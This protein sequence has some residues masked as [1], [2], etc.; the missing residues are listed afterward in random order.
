MSAI[1]KLNDA[2]YLVFIV[3][4]QA[5]IARGYYNAASVDT[6]HEW[7]AGE[8]SRIGAHIDDI[9]YCPHHPEGTV[10]GLSKACD[11]R[12]PSTGMLDS[13]IAQWNPDLS[14]SFM[15]GDT[16]KDA[17]AGIAA[18]VHAKKIEPSSILQEVE[19]LLSER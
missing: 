6:L 18:G 13:L 5:G 3:T 15:L 16:D 11:C 8:L 14:R 19:L 2:G 1:R 4:N 7:M 10:T 12:K 17:E 9:R